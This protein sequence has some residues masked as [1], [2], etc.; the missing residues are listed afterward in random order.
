[1]CA[2]GSESMVSSA[3]SMVGVAWSTAA[4]TEE[5]VSTSNE[6]SCMMSESFLPE[7]LCA[8][9]TR[10]SFTR[11]D[12]A[13]PSVWT[14]RTSSPTTGRFAASFQSGEVTSTFRASLS[15]TMVFTE[16]LRASVSP[17]LTASLRVESSVTMSSACPLAVMAER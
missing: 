16:L 6:P 1:M 11:A 12:E 17:L 13:A 15:S 10:A 7:T 4:T 5:M 9:G 14:E 8:M 3:P 2:S